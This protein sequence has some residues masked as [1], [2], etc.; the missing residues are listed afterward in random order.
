M[1]TN[2]EPN[3]SNMLDE[4]FS[5]ARGQRAERKAARQAARQER[6]A[7]KTAARVERRAT[8]TTARVAKKAA[9]Q[10]RKTMRV[11]GRMAKR[12]RVAPVAEAASV[13][14]INNQEAAV[15]EQAQAPAEQ[16]QENQGM[17]QG[18]GQGEGGGQEN[19]RGEGNEGGGEEGFDGDSNFFN[20]GFDGDSN[21]D[22]TPTANKFINKG[23]LIGAG[24]GA[25]ALLA[26]AHFSKGKQHGKYVK[27][28]L[29]GLAGGAIIMG[30]V[31]YF[32]K[33]D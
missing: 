23:T 11:Q 8:K 33:K 26:V 9:R 30:A 12:G 7:T 4:S 21:A 14:E 32:N 31:S 16:A 10:E 13:E 27:L 15:A 6:R 19:N 24:I 20:D 22:G 18:V 3:I 29:I 1:N 17:G 2:F 28:G 5:E 25:A